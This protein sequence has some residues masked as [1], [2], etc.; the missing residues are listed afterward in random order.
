MSRAGLVARWLILAVIAAVLAAG[1]AA[2][3]FTYVTNSSAHTYFKIPSGWSKIDQD[4]LAAAF[5][6][7]TPP[8]TVWTVGYDAS[9]SP[10][11]A[12]VVSSRVAK[13]FAY[14]VVEPLNQTTVD[15]LSYNMLR[16]MFLPVTSTA[17][18]KAATSGFPLTGFKLIRDA[19]LAPGDGV[20]GI[21]ETFD[22]TYPDGSTDTFD[23]VALTNAD[24]TEVYMLLVH[25]LATCYSQHSSEINTVM[26]SFTVRSH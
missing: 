5:N 18:Q 24:G 10:A 17:R 19:R 26:T 20:H 16:D 14:A 15:N 3:H 7:G 25:C 4:A 11:A 13:P 8:S 2:P 1:C 12:D 6:S 23:Q 22:Y 21:R 9:T